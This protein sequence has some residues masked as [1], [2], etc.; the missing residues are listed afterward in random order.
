[1]NNEQL[2][3]QLT[4][5]VAMIVFNR[6]QTTKKVFE[7]IRQV[8][9]PVL[10]LIADGPRPDKP[11]EDKKCAAV[12][13]IIEKV[14]WDCQVYKN[15]SDVNLG[16]GKRPSTGIDWVFDSVEEAIIIEDDCLPDPSFFRYCQEL[17]DYYRDDERVM[18]ICGLNVQ[19]GE[20]PTDY[21]Y[22]FSRYNHC[23]GWASWRRAWKYFDF[24][25]KV[26]PEIR[27]KNLLQDILQDSHAV[28]SWTHTFDIISANQLD[29]WDFQWIFAN[30]VHGGLAITPREN[31]I[32]YIG[33]TEDATHTTN[34][35]SQYNQLE[36]KAMEFPLKHPP[37]IIRH[38]KADRYT[39]STYFDYQPNLYK[40][41]N[42][43]VRKILGL[44]LSQSW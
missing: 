39:E 3:W 6:P 1:M 28:K 29:C 35:L 24:D 27:E 9:P 20:N 31:L 15:Y 30:W 21:S 22:Y 40:R 34:A 13:E 5:P 37:F 26:W 10:F 36:V 7:A 44:K 25:L 38:D 11:G 23:W 42:R 43:K 33:Y 16:C 14:D 4:T 2:N 12:R 8:K 19:F 17:L 32:K 41:I 18:T